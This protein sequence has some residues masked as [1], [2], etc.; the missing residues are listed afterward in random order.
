MK[1]CL[2]EDDL[3]LG[4]ALKSALEDEGIGVV[5]LRLGRDVSHFLQDQSCDAAVLDLGLPDADGFSVLKDLRRA[6]TDVPILVISARDGLEEPASLP[7][8]RCRRLL[9]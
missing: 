5:W 9:N 2:I 7:G 4:S 3:D 8:C 6:G 1:V